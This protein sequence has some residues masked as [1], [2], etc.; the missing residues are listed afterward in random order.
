[1]DRLRAEIPLPWVEERDYNPGLHEFH[2]EFGRSR[3]NCTSICE[4]SAIK[5]CLWSPVFKG[6]SRSSE[7]TLSHRVHYDFLFVIRS[8]YGPILYCFGNK[9]QY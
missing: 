2:A 9:R 7:V 1:M 5:L 4:G 3:S 6:L 8:D